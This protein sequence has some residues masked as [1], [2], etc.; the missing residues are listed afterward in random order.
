V[1]PE[2]K[3]TLAEKGWPDKLSAGLIGSCTNS[4]YEDMTRSAALTEQALKAGLKFK[5]RPLFLPMIGSQI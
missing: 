4:S 3:K 1:G 2:F 5:V